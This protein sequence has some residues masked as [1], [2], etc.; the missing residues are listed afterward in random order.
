MRQQPLDLLRNLYGYDSFRGR[1]AEVIDHVLA[2]HDA[3]MLAPTGGGKSLCYQIPALLREGTGV[4]VSPL[5][6][7]MQ[8]QVAALRQLGVRAAFLN[9]T[10]S[11][12]EKREVA[13]DLRA[14]NLDLLYL[15]PERIVLGETLELLADIKP[16]LIAID[17]AHCVSQW[18]HDF[19]PEYLQLDILRERFPGVPR[20]ACTATADA[21]TRTE[22]VGNLKLDGGRIF[23]TGFDRPN[24]RYLVAERSGGAAQLMRFLRNEHPGQAGIVYCLSRK[25]TERVAEQLANAGLDALPYHAGL[26]AEVR[27]ANQRR[28]LNE[29]GVVICATIAFGMGIDKP[30]VRFVVHVDMP[31]GLEAYYQETGRAGRDGL[32]ATAL[33]TYGLQDVVLRRRMLENSEADDLHKRAERQRLD[34]MLAYCELVTC[35]RQTLLRHFGDELPEPCGNCD[36]C[37]T[38][39][40]TF[41][42]TVAAQKLLSCVARTGQRFGANYV[43]DV[44]LGSDDERIT[45]FGHDQLSTHG[46]GGELDRNG[47]RA[48]VRQLMARGLLAPDAE[49]HGSLR[50]TEEARAVLAGEETLQL[51]K[52]PMRAPGAGRKRAGKAARVAL[53]DAQDDPDVTARFER[54][55]ELRLQLSREA[56]V[57]PYVVFHDKTL[58]AMAALRPQNESELMEISGVGQSKLEKWGAAFLEALRE[59][60]DPA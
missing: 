23:A 17:E 50:L 19:R 60:V 35:R 5:I 15:A 4:V 41:D 26:P 8:D 3:L 38:P 25:K 28:F 33:L 14:G 55:R 16:S 13:T 57:P 54:L 49:G 39:P 27:A 45:R 43:I 48:V 58:V 31:S 30:D 51:R 22:I 44:L 52:D 32:P 9:S 29:D 46:I 47:W 24:I 40:E 42:A 6:A 34:A 36:V 56:N 21:R 20:L 7:L 53:A 1:Q 12:A 2:G 11:A 59:E 18:G 10:L 37:L